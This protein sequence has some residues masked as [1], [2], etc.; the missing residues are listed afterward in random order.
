M[1]SYS[2]NPKS[3]PQLVLKRYR[4]VTDGKTDRITIANTCYS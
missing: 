1:L 3:L 4:V 2:E